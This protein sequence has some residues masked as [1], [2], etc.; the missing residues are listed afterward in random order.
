M[1]IRKRALSTVLLLFLCLGL[2][3]LL[4]VEGSYGRYTISGRYSASP[5]R[6]LRQL[7]L[8]EA[9]ELCRPE[10][11]IILYAAGEHLLLLHTDI[12][13]YS[14]CKFENDT[15]FLTTSLAFSPY[16][17]DKDIW[18]PVY[19]CT[20]SP[21]AAYAET[22]LFISSAALSDDPE[23]PM[24]GEY[25]FPRVACEKG[26]AC[27]PM[28][29]NS[30]FAGEDTLINSFQNCVINGSSINGIYYRALLRFYDAEGELLSETVFELGKK[31]S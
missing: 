26:V 9:E 16:K 24:Q 17:F 10:E 11:D 6:I 4:W 21:D 27:F 12:P 28:S 14:L 31:E 19:A 20:R 22:E 25:L 29:W 13:F 8:E 23:K 2:I 5:D 1:K 3:F 15:A 7:M 30:R 18:L